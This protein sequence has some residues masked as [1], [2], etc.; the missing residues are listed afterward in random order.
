MEPLYKNEYTINDSRELSTLPS[1]EEDEEDVLYNVESLF[2]N[3]PVKQNRSL[4]HIYVQKKLTPICM[5]LMLKRLLLKRA[6]EWKLTFLN[7][8]HQ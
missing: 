1:L 8:F 2:T 6:T 3:I 7:I 4:H 5:K